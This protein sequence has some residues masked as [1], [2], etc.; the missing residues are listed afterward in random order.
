LS[1]RLGRRERPR[2]RSPDTRRQAR[3]GY[4]TACVTASRAPRMAL[5][6]WLGRRNHDG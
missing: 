5:I 1:P 3:P 4:R 2:A 6:A